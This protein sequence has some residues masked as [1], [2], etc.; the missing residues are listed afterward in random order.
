MELYNV[1]SIAKSLKMSP[2][3]LRVLSRVHFDKISGERYYNWQGDKKYELFTKEQREELKNIALNARTDRDS[4]KNYGNKNRR[5]YRESKGAYSK[6]KVEELDLA[7][8]KSENYYLMEESKL[9]LPE[10]DG[11]K[12]SARE[13]MFMSNLA[14]KIPV[15]GKVVKASERHMVMFLKIIYQV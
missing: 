8:R 12:I 15:Y 5:I 13:E 4:E 7:L 11:Y 9:F 6:Y 10:I 1:T 3:T 14:E 2:Y